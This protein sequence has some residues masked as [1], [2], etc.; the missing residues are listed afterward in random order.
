MLCALQD[1]LSYKNN[2]QRELIQ[3]SYSSDHRLVPK[4][5]FNR[6][7]FNILATKPKKKAMTNVYTLRNINNNGRRLGSAYEQ[8]L[9]EELYSALKSKAEINDLSEK[10]VDK[11][12]G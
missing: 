12:S 9:K 11:Y 4:S 2:F 3:F 7:F 8:E 6:I 5:I 10:L 1:L